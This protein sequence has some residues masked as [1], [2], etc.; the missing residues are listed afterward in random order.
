MLG[1][2]A[3]PYRRD[4][5][6]K[7]IGFYLGDTIH[8]VDASALIDA[9]QVLKAEVITRE[10]SFRTRRDPSAEYSRVLSELT[11][12]QDRNRLICRDVAGASRDWAGIN[13]VLSDR[14]GHCE[15]LRLILKAEHG[16][17][18]AVLTGD[19]PAKERV[20]LVDRLNTGKIKTLI[21]TGQLIG[22][23]FDC[24]ELSTLFLAT[25]VKF[26]GRVL[27]YMGRVLRPAPGK[28]AAR[29]LDYIDV[30]VPVLAAGAK[31]RQQVYRGEA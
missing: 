10:T 15:A 21:A 8:T 4:G 2:S 5:L 9:G 22:E 26:S 12:D 7:V 18:A 3:T 14:K 24:R 27:Q 11:A 16:I 23:G 25:P 29:V 28:E 1:L 6:S 31:A 30:H 13:L 20:A 17:D 19:L